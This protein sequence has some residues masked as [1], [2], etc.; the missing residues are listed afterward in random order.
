MREGAPS[1]IVRRRRDLRRLNRAGAPPIARVVSPSAPPRV[2]VYAPYNRW[3]LHGQWLTTIVHGLRLRG[4]ET[5]YVLCDGL[6]TDC[7]VFWAS[8]EPRPEHACTRCQAEVTQ[9]LYRMSADFE[10]LGRYLTL[11]ERREARRWERSLERDQL[12]TAAYGEWPV[13]EWIAGSVHSHFRLNA[14]DPDV[15]DVEAA[16]RSYLYSGLVAC[17]ALERLLADD[18]PDALL[19][20]NG[21]VSSPRIAF[22]LARRR[23]IRVVCLES[24]PR[25]ETIAL[26]VN[27]RCVSF[28]PLDQAWE[29]W[30]DVPLLPAEVATMAAQLEARERGTDFAFRSFNPPPQHADEVR[31]RLGLEPGRPVWAVFTSSDDEVVA[32][33]EWQGPFAAQLDWIERTVAFAAAHPAIDLVV[34]VHPNT[35]GRVSN[36]SNLRQLEE[37]SALASRLPA[38]ARIV[39][40]DDEISSYSLMDLAAVGLVYH[41]MVG[42]ELACKGKAVVVAGANQVAG[43]SFVH[44]VTDSRRYEELL[45][46]LLEL[47]AAATRDEVRVP[48]WRFAYARFFRTCV[49]F[50]LVRMPDGH[51]GTLAY[52]SFDALLPGRDEGLDRTLEVI[53]RDE[54]VC[55]PPGAAERTRSAGEELAAHRSLREP[56]F[57]AAAFAD[58][59]IADPTILAAWGATFGPDDGATLLVETPGDLLGELVAAVEAA[60]LAADGTAEIVVVDTLPEGVAAAVSRR[61]PGPLPTFAPERATELRT[62]AGRAA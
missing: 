38:N 56:A 13:A 57:A 59:V 44:T 3:L 23:G 48:A 54:P 17:F 45:E 30:R 2:L 40:P 55:L 7:D 31:S 27:E 15:A 10:W 49:P 58:E 52:D 9:L 47:P 41:S 39:M 19:I 35:A 6:Y 4:A 8:T 26:T 20:F 43:T 53:L 29:Q 25:L 14:L 28:R 62:L 60:G 22:E 61:P 36:G 1:V 37:L 21:R 42:L 12:L 24:G 32:E 33:S 16:L 46:P 18:E 51:S 11:D 5:H 50:P 34:R